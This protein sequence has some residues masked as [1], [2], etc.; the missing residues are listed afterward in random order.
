MTRPRAP[1]RDVGKHPGVVPPSNMI[2]LASTMLSCTDLYRRTRPN[3]PSVTVALGACRES[4][5]RVGGLSGGHAGRRRADQAGSTAGPT[6]LS[7]PA[8]QPPPPAP[9]GS[10]ITVDSYV[11]DLGVPVEDGKHGW[12]ADASSAALPGRRRASQAVPAV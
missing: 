3:L 11:R 2:G 5:V 12:S 6:R 1:P 8:A 7:G 4:T 10:Y 9:P